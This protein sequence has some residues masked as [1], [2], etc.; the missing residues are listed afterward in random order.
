[1]RLAILGD[2]PRQ[3]DKIGGGVEAVISYLVQGLRQFPD[4]ELHVVTLCEDVHRVEVVRRNGMTAHYVPAD[5]R[6]ANL[7]FF[8]RNK[9][10]LRRALRAIQPDLIH[11]HI[12]GTYAH[13]AFGMGRPAVLTPHGIRYR[14]AQIKRGWLNRMLRY[15]LTRY[16]EWVGIRVA[17]HIISI[18]PYVVQEFAS[19]I[20]GQ[21]YPIENPI[22]DAFFHLTGQEI[23]TRLLF[24]GQISPRKGVYPLLQ[25]MTRVRERLPQVKL[26][27]A[28]KVV[29]EY[30][31]TH[32][33]TV[34]NYVRDH[35]LQDHVLF[36]GQLDEQTLL[37][38]YAQ[39][40]VFVLPSRQETAPM[41]IEQA[42]AAGKPVVAT[43]VGG[44]PHLISHGQ[45]GLLVEHGDVTGLAGAIS[46]LLSDDAL[47]ARLGERAKQEASRRF[48]AEVV[49]RKTY[50][51]Y[52][53]ILEEHPS[54]GQE[55]EG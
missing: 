17:R 35:Q 52:R 9:L 43:R 44:V 23:P 7:T 32:F 1:M 42:M 50:R 51:V 40:A 38:E 15:P 55:R 30:D 29:H 45:T 41:A 12:A 25:A 16:D 54:A 49:A 3:P 11:A 20:R 14:E 19:A 36:L 22:S 27:L 53:K 28:G 5:Y 48:R 13:V 10:R 46:R 31:P 47:R 4:L 33:Q 34:Q 6:F 39:C 24:V 18:S 37:R 2:Y 21:V 8:I 26:H